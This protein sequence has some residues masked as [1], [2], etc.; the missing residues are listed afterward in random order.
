MGTAH[1]DFGGTTSA[2]NVVTLRGIGSNVLMPINALPRYLS[3][4]IS[5]MAS[6]YN[7]EMEALPDL[8]APPHALIMCGAALLHPAGLWDVTRP[9]LH[10]RCGSVFKRMGWVWRHLTPSEFLRAYDML[11]RMD[12]SLTGD[13]RARNV[14]VRGLSPLI[15]DSIFQAIWAGGI[16]GGLGLECER[17]SGE[18]T[19][20]HVDTEEFHGLAMDTVSF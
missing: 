16:G 2:A 8:D 4:V 13:K 11:L 1:A 17:L 3:H 19:S 14:L 7:Q 20:L 12:A 10:I 6:T 9:E 15:A 18:R 5:P